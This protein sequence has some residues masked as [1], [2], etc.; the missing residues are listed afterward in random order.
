MAVREA[1]L[2]CL[3]TG[4]GKQGADRRGEQACQQAAERLD[5]RRSVPAADGLC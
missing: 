4:R 1:G 3:F 5:R 2:C